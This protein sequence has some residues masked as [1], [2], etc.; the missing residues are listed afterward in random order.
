MRT[1]EGGLS[2]LIGPVRVNLAATNKLKAPGTR[3]E[4][5]SVPRHGRRG[6]SG[7]GLA[8]ASFR[9]GR[10]PGAVP[11]STPVRLQGAYALRKDAKDGF[12]GRLS[13]DHPWP[14]MLCYRRRLPSLYVRS[15]IRRPGIGF[16]VF[17]IWPYSLSSPGFNASQASGSIR[18]AQR[19]KRRLPWQAQR[20]PSLARYALLPA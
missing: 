11:V 2:L 19:R 12:P 20:G 6:P 10:V 14:A 16:S 7:Q 3:A 5:E 15:S 13:A 8:L 18:L 1:S 9:S 17:P 4:E